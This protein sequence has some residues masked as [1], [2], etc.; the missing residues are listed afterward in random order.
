MGLHESQALHKQLS[1][2]QSQQTRS[3]QMEREKGEGAPGRTQGQDPGPSGRQRGEG[4]PGR[5][6]RPAVTPCTVRQEPD[7]VS[8]EAQVWHVAVA[9]SFHQTLKSREHW[10]GHHWR[11]RS[12]ATGHREQPA[13]QGTSG[14]STPGGRA[15]TLA[16]HLQTAEGCEDPTRPAWAADLT[17]GDWPHPS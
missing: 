1:H 2:S 3:Q 8:V 5:T 14:Q 6:E 11:Q 9:V 17:G 12:D 15:S 7:L 16:R 10:S 13:S 4:A